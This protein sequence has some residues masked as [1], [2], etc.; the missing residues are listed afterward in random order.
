MDAI[1]QKY[2]NLYDQAHARMVS[3]RRD[4]PG[5]KHQRET[6]ERLK[7]QIREIKRIRKERNR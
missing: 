1:L 3:M 2:Q 6:A 4:S 7:K 5:Y